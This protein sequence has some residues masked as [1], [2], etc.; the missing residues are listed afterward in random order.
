MY[1][2]V[3]CAPLD[4]EQRCNQGSLLDGSILDVLRRV[5]SEPWYSRW[6]DLRGWLSVN[7]QSPIYLPWNSY[8]QYNCDSLSL[9]HSIA[10]HRRSFRG[11]RSW[12]NLEGRNQVGRSHV[13]SCITATLRPDMWPY[14][15]KWVAWIV[16][17]IFRFYSIVAYIALVSH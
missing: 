12:M 6:H 15:P 8:H 13:S 17:E 3:N 5:N 2:L 14:L 1:P 4:W 16:S 11:N 7:N 9:T 10:Y